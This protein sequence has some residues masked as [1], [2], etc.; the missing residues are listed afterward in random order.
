MLPGEEANV[1]YKCCLILTTPL[2]LSEWYLVTI[3]GTIKIR[4]WFLKFIFVPWRTHILICIYCLYNILYYYSRSCVIY[5][6]TH[7]YMQTFHETLLVY[8]IHLG[9]LYSV[10]FYSAEKDAAYD[11][12]S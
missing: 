8:V 4:L 7:T 12:Q 9:V 6:Y 10:P 5:V 1:F 11:P 2:R 3:W